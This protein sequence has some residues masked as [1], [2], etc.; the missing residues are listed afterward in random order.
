M[1]RNAG[2]DIGK[3]KGLT[4]SQSYKDKAPFAFTGKIE[5]VVFDLTPPKKTGK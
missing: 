5:K 2:T 1:T 4:V 3:D